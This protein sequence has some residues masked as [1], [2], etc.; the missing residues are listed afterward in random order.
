MS[1]YA[2]VAEIKSLG[3]QTRATDENVWTLLAAGASRDFDRLCEVPD[4]FF[5]AA[6]YD[7][8]E[9]P[10][11]IYADRVFI[12]DGTAYLKLDPFVTLNPDEPIVIDPDFAYAVP[13]YHV[14]GRMLIVLSK[15]QLQPIE[16]SAYPGRFAGWKQ[17]VK[18]T[19]SAHWG[20]AAI[21]ADVKLAVCKLAMHAWRLSDPVVAQ[22]TGAVVEDLI[23]GLPQS[24][25]PIVEKYRRIYTRA[26][27]FA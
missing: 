21:P 17:G 18:I 11:P 9:P 6:A 19:V 27:A 16:L 22:D 14:N 25:W 2:T 26:A 20:F 13:T 5:A 10:E 7:D 8:E 1:D 23:D 12:G 4:D 24:V 15:T 3:L